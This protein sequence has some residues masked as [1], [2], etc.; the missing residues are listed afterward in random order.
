MAG[1]SPLY[2]PVRGTTP[3][4]DEF[5]DDMNP[6]MGMQ[7]V[8]TTAPDEPPAGMFEEQARQASGLVPPAVGSDAAPQTSAPAAPNELDERRQLVEYLNK[9]HAADIKQGLSD[10]DANKVNPEELRES[11]NDNRDRQFIAGLSNSL[12]AVGNVRGNYAKSTL[13]EFANEI[14]KSD[15]DYFASRGQMAKAGLD[16]AGQGQKGLTDVETM[17][18]KL[19]EME[20]TAAKRDPNSEVSKGY[21][22]ALAGLGLTVPENISAE[23]IEKAGLKDA[24]SKAYTKRI[25]MEGQAQIAKFKAQEMRAMKDV[26]REQGNSAREDRRQAQISDKAT[27]RFDELSHKLNE[28]VQS[29]RTTIGRAS[30]GIYAA[31]KIGSLLDQADAQGGKVTQQQLAEVASALDSMVKGGQATVSGIEHMMP[32]T[33]EG[34]YGDVASFLSSSPKPQELKEYLDMMRDTVKREK[35][36]SQ[37]VIGDYKKKALSSYHD[38]EKT[39]PEKYNEIMQAHG[40][41]GASSGSMQASTPAPAPSVSDLPVWTPEKAVGVK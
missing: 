18:A 6:E 37:K 5:N 17:Q 33:L 20:N 10:Y 19:A 34:K 16:L 25:Q 29:S 30:N 8:A 13:P 27:K 39:D 9:R 21:R 14:E 4:V 22:Q 40:L 3:P 41:S 12:A 2:H 1:L 32:H 28:D 38:L 35:A 36:V 24:A 31:D 11:R 23:G 7:D 15:K 26:A